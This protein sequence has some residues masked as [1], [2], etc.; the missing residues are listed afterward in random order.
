MII[1]CENCS[2]KF[3]VKK[4]QIDEG[5]RFVRC[6]NCEYE[7]L[8]FRDNTIDVE[9][10]HIDHNNSYTTQPPGYKMWKRA[11]V[12]L[13]STFATMVLLLL[14]FVWLDNSAINKIQR[15][16]TDINIANK[17][18]PALSMSDFAV[19]SHHQNRNNNIKTK[20]NSLL[21]F[22][23]KNRTGNIYN[24]HLIRVFGYNKEGKITFTDSLSVNDKV[25]PKSKIH[26]VFDLDD[27]IDKLD[28][29]FI[30]VNDEFF[31]KKRVKQA[32]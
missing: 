13:L 32:N 4:N 21:Q 5:G 9:D 16:A 12:V 23:I 24:I 28:T 2:S 31:T 18:Q 14:F 20:A 15:I 6:S 19:V 25:E 3:F 27:Q 17:P 8:A 10:S 26:F 22:S 29:L 11:I 7:W 1:T 30:E